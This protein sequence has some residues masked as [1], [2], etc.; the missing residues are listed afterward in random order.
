MVATTCLL[1]ALLSVLTIAPLVNAFALLDNPGA[2]R[3]TLVF[4]SR[5]AVLPL[6]DVDIAL[7]LLPVLP[8][9]L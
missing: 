4:R 7:P 5:L 2:A 8:G 3:A 9:A 1:S 6:M